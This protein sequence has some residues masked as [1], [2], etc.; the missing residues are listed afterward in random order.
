MIDQR[1]CAAA[2][3]KQ[4]C[5]AVYDNAGN[6]LNIR[7]LLK[8]KFYLTEDLMIKKSMQYGMSPYG[9]PPQFPRPTTPDPSI[10]HRDSS[11][12]HS[13]YFD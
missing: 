8:F 9:L 11:Q 10:P 3:T 12:I 6:N 2:T 7:S 4:L 13:S 5:Y 1:V